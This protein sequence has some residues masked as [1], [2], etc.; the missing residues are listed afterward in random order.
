MEIILVQ[1]KYNVIQYTFLKLFNVHGNY[2]L[3]IQSYRIQMKHYAV[4][5][6][7]IKYYII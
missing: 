6:E 5:I 7:K 4:Q 2:L 1:H 3:Q